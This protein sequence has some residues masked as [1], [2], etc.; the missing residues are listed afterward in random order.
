MAELLRMHPFQI[1]AFRDDFPLLKQKVNNK[2]LCYFDNAA[3]TQKMSATIDAINEYYQYDN[4]NVHRGSYALSARATTLFEQARIEVKNYLNANSEKEIIWTKGTTEAINLVANAWGRANLLPGDEIVLSQSEHHANI[5]S[6]QIIAEQTGAVIKVLPLLP[7]GCIDTTC[8]EQYITEKTKLVACCHI[9]NVIGKVN[10]IASIIAKAKTVN[11]KT[12]I[13]G[14]QAIAHLTVDVQAL[15]CDFY[16]FSSHKFYG[17]TGLGVL[18]GKESLLTEMPPYQGGGEMVAQVSFTGTSYNSLPFKF[19]AGTPNIAAVIGFKSALGSFQRWDIASIQAYEQTLT[20]YAFQ[21]LSLIDELKFIVE[22][23]PDMSIFSFTINAHH[24][25][26]VAAFLD[27]Q[28]IAVRCGHHCAMPLMRYLNLDG[29]IRVSL[30]AYNTIAE[31]DQLVTALKSFISNEHQLNNVANDHNLAMVAT[32]D[33]RAAV[34]AIVAEFNQ[35]K[36]WDAKHRAIM[37]YG[38]ALKRLPKNLRSDSC[39]ISGCESK[40]WLVAEQQS[41]G[42]YQFHCDSD[43]RVIRGLMFITTSA[44]QNLTSAEILAFDIHVFFEKLGL[45]QHLSPSRSNGLNAIVD[46]IRQLVNV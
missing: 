36:S 22:K 23:Q 29:C 45:T 7:D 24:N 3:T 19:E 16:V 42:R 28:G 2:T 25:Q 31:I 38:K 39:L 40:A 43:A 37:L 9:S 1:S 32:Q 13:D 18:Y 35:A 8:L 44:Y 30:T 11:A 10:D 21:Q 34:E 26:D 15:D 14:A 12:L 33:D 46:R 27:T 5:V 17:P 6:W 20:R 41:D 4:A